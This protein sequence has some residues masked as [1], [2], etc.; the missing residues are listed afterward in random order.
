MFQEP[1]SC[2]PAIPGFNPELGETANNLCKSLQEQA[3]Q[4]WKQEVER[5]GAE[6][7]PP[8]RA[9]QV[10]ELSATAIQ[11]LDTLLSPLAPI[12]GSETLAQA[13]EQLDSYERIERTAARKRYAALDALSDLLPEHSELRRVVEELER[14]LDNAAHSIAELTLQPW[15]TRHSELHRVVK[16]LEADEFDRLHVREGREFRDRKRLEAELTEIIAVTTLGE[17]SQALL[18]GIVVPTSQ[19]ASSTVQQ[20]EKSIKQMVT[21]T[22]S[23]NKAV[24]DTSLDASFLDLDTEVVLAFAQGIGLLRLLEARAEI[25]RLEELP[26][27]RLQIFGDHGNW[28]VSQIARKCFAQS[29]AHLCQLKA[30]L[31]SEGVREGLVVLYLAALRQEQAYIAEFDRI[32]LR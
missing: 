13:R 3:T 6:A 15:N 10:A 28:E 32:T 18:A 17:P 29:I 27:L 1:F 21:G 14:R 23:S 30:P 8:E 31:V 20:I 26:H 19:T 7:L 24:E 11:S 16:E 25:A 9:A 2:S 22:P 5:F 12:S 4:F